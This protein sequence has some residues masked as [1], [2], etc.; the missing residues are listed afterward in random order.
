MM[1]IVKSCQ[2]SP[3]ALV[4][5][6]EVSRFWFEY[7]PPWSIEFNEEE[8]VFGALLIEVLV[9]EDHDAIIHFGGRSGSEREE[10][11]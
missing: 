10:G 4:D 7:L 11:G 9:R 5:G 3:L 8:L 1:I 6:V 2:I